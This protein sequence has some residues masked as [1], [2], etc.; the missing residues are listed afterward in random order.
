MALRLNQIF[1]SGFVKEGLVV[2]DKSTNKLQF[3]QVEKS[4]QKISTIGI[5]FSNQHISDFFH[6][7]TICIANCENLTIGHSLTG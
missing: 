1:H 4:I 5:R 7:Q 3:I 6:D 2:V